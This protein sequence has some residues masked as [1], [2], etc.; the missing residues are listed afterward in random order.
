[1][2]VKC[3]N[4]GFKLEPDIWGNYDSVLDTKDGETKEWFWC[5]NCYNSFTRLLS[6]DKYEIQIDTKI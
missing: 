2:I 6:E 3:P 5:R 1:M 4:C